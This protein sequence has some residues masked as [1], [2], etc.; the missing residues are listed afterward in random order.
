MR[1]LL[2]IPLA[3]A[4]AC[5]GSQA[6]K[7]QSRDAL[8]SKDA[9]AMGAPS[10]S[11][12]SSSTAQPG[13][14][15]QNSTVGQ[16]SPFFD[17][18]VGVAAVFNGGTAAM[19]GIIENVT[20]TDPTSCTATSC[21][22]GPG[23]SPLDYNVFKL[24]VTKNGDGYDWEL[25]GQDKTQPT[26]AFVSFMSG[27]AVPGAQPHHGSGAFQIDFDKAATLPGPHDATGQLT[28]NSYTNVGPAQ[29]DVRYIGAKDTDPGH[30]GQFNNILYTYANNATGG[31]DLDFA[32]H[33]TTTQDKFSVHSRWKND[34]TGR[35]DVQ[36]TG[37]GVSVQLSECWGAAP[38]AVV[39]FHS[40]VT[41]N[42]A[43]FGGPDAGA[44]S[45]CAFIPAAFSTK[46]AP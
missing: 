41:L 43:P 11:S 8:P 44:E 32:L 42:I 20:A 17:L 21:T 45:A 10:S 1:T 26:S 15:T 27:H 13:Q 29:L 40:T 31:G 16:H 3:A 28:V 34:G 18:T 30:A 37:S 19:L 39:Y 4:V 46:T 35:A 24:V 38:F 9:V 5:G 36:G 33:N 7:D 22:W 6:L 12:G 25:S 23:S 14:T 2:A